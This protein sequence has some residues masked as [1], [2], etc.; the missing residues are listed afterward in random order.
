[1]GQ[2][3]RY[4]KMDLAYEFLLTKEQE[5]QPFSI[6]ALAE[7]VGW[8]METVRTYLSKRWFQYIVRSDD[9]YIVK[10]ISALNKE[11]FRNLQSQSLRK[12]QVNDLHQKN[13]LLKKA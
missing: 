11:D 10:G 2:E 6:K 1:M 8:E 13:G 4:R 9:D 12:A 3:T 7:Y 5:D